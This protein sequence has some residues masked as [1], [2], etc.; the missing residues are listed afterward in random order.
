MASNQS[1]PRPRG[2]AT[3][4]LQ[5]NNINRN[6]RYS[7][8]ETPVEMQ[9][10]VFQQFSSPTNSTIDE[11]PISPREGIP[12]VTQDTIRSPFLADKDLV[13]RAGSPYNVQPPQEIHPAH[14]A[15]Y[16][17]EP[18][19]RQAEAHPS[20]PKPQTPGPIPIKTH[21]VPRSL[22]PTPMR[23]APQEQGKTSATVVN[24]D[25]GG[26]SLVYNPLSPAGPNAAHGDHRP[27]QVS[28]PNAAIQ[29]EWKHGFCEMDTL[30]CMGVVCPC[31]VY[32]KT[33]YRVSRKTQKQD[34][35]DLLG[36][37]QCNGSCGLMAVACGFQ[38]E[39]SS[40]STEKSVLTFLGIFA[41]IQR[42][43]IRKMYHLS[44]SLGSDCFKSLCC[45]C[46]VLMQNER[47]VRDR[48][49]LIR[50]H[51]GPASGPY[52]TPGPMSYAPPPR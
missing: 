38:C 41:S 37:S 22:T 36:Y 23:T 6:P 30:C 47:E 28:H 5:T 44:G 52:I 2:V 16:A 24:P 13:A 35:T 4:L 26:G 49:E 7:Y 27:G 34:P 51:A 19:I 9:R 42:T 10:S 3:G 11:S 15:P 8:M 25:V 50:R 43:R 29:P 12:N 46:C 32:G 39:Y 21:E 48:E 17:E 33:Q 40:S 14:F 20:A 18:V 45:C 31:M 1:G